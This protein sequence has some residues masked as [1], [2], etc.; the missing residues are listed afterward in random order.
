M[1]KKYEKCFGDHPFST[2]HH[3]IATTFISRG[4]KLSIVNQHTIY[5]AFLAIF[6]NPIFM[7]Y[8]LLDVILFLAME[9]MILVVSD[10]SSRSLS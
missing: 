6:L 2:C 9:M 1:P 3:Q 8:M 10:G 7:R 5:Y 4:L